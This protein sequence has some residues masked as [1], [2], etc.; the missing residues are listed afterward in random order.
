MHPK[1]TISEDAIAV[2]MSTYNG[3]DYVAEQIDSLINQ[4]HK[5]W[6]CYIR[7]DGSSDNTLAI[8]SSY[9]K[10]D[11]RFT[12]IEDIKSNLGAI[13]SYCYL[14]SITTESYIAT[15]DQDDVWHSNKLEVS[16]KKLKQIETNQ[17]IPA[18]VHTNS[19]FVDS[20]LNVIREKFIT[21]RGM[22][23]GLNE[24]LFA[25]SAQGG[26]L[27]FNAG[28]R[29]AIVGVKP[30]LPYDYHLAIIA[31]LVGTRAFIPETLLKYRQHT[32]SS[33]AIADTNLSDMLVKADY[34]ATLLLS[35]NMYYHLKKDFSN[36]SATKAAQSNLDDYFYLFEG[37]SRLKKIFIFFKNRY[38]FYSRKDSLSFFYL[39]LKNTDLKT[40]VTFH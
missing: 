10:L 15:C 31:N 7:D 13:P 23:T 8:L 3:S 37:T 5:N 26:S 27:I 34:S 32:A 16:L 33:T 2:V 36:I 18:L 24:I 38:S 28:L 19:V 14:I 11:D 29:S 4:T 40:L 9:T 1:T 35:L 22:S 6:H 12:I 39:L 17:K 30:T 20:Q 21:H 25:N